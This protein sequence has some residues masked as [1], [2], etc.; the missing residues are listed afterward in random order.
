MLKLNIVWCLLL[1]RERTRYSWGTDLLCFPYG[2]FPYDSLLQ[3]ISGEAGGITNPWSNACE[4]M[5]HGRIT[6]TSIVWTSHMVSS[7]YWLRKEALRFN[8][9]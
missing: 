4:K 6:V 9:S 1:S 7:C 5:T 2:D 3:D 8:K